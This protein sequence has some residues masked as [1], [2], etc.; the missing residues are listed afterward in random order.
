MMCESRNLFEIIVDVRY[1]GRRCTGKGG[2]GVGGGGGS[3][4]IK[5][6]FTFFLY[7]TE[8]LGFFRLFPH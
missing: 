6:N 4:L 3:E 1:F 7:T 2:G 5:V 8:I